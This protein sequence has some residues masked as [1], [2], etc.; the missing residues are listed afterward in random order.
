MD[1]VI[2]A[3][4]DEAIDLALSLYEYFWVLDLKY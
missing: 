1:R 2:G 3:M 4:H